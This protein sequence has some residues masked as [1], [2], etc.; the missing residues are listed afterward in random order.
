MDN[1]DIL[2]KI[3]SAKQLPIYVIFGEE[4]YFREKAINL[5]IEKFVDKNTKDFNFNLLRG[6][7]IE[8]GFLYNC[9]T[10]I[11]MM[12]E[13]R[14][15][16]IKNADFITG[17]AIKVLVKYIKNPVDSTIL[18]L[19]FEKKIEKKVSEKSVSEEKKKTERKEEDS[20]KK[21]LFLELKPYWF[22]FKKIYDKQIPSYIYDYTKEKGIKI[23]KDAIDILIGICGTSFKDLTNE[24]DKMILY[25]GKRKEITKE[26]VIDITGSS[27]TYN[28]FELLESF[29]NKKLNESLKIA[30]KILERGDVSFGQIIV[31]LTW[32]LSILLKIKEYENNPDI[33]VISKK[34]GFKYPHVTEKYLKQSRNFS[35]EEIE[36]CFNY[37]LYTDV[38][39]K[40]GLKNEK[41]LMDI[42]MTRMIDVETSKNNV[43]KAKIKIDKKFDIFRE[44]SEVY[45]VR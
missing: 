31:M 30:Y 1:R 37:V 32:H 2:K 25:L 12:S 38:L 39:K 22:E 11:P 40:S 43:S 4:D 9:L 26:D 18:I 44:L 35:I 16:L 41:L 10:S 15:V 42:L 20:D 3:E 45:L 14:I 28:I 7:D 6:D 34:L 8:A 19:E 36:R 27:K 21:Q 5:L 13:K 29:G 23:S 33:N 17:D 24:I